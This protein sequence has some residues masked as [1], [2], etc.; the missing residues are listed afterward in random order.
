VGRLAGFA[1]LLY[2]AP[3]STEVPGLRYLFAPLL[4]LTHPVN[5]FYAALATLPA[6]A[7]AAVCLDRIIA[8]SKGGRRGDPAEPDPGALAAGDT[9]GVGR[10]V[11][12]VVAGLTV[13]RAVLPERAF[14]SDFE[15]GLYLL[16]LGQAVAVAAGMFW[17]L[18]R[19]G[20]RLAHGLF[21]LALIDLATMGLRFHLALPATPLPWTERTE[22]SDVPLRGGYL[23]LTELADLE[24]FQYDGGALDSDAIASEI[25][26][27]SS[28]LR[29]MAAFLQD[30][31]LG[32]RWPIHLGL[33]RGLRTGPPGG[34]SR[35][36]AL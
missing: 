2:L 29:T 11:L 9:S 24:P 19:G 32:R 25:E 31:L 6:A 33:S 12:A 13:L 23:H 8:A 7:A 14:F 27:Q 34:P 15:W 22:V 5:H 35:C 4:V 30:D 28:R 1:L 21:A 3:V 18:W 10:Y 26:E 20:P 17:L 16:A 36:S